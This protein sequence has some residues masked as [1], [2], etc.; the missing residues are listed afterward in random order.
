MLFNPF[1]TG[2]PDLTFFP[3]LLVLGI[4]SG[5]IGH[6]DNESEIGFL[7]LSSVRQIFGFSIVRVMSRVMV[8]VSF[9]LAY[10]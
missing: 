3:I 9:G 5:M 2:K 4:Y 8:R 6:A 10:L 7:I 1:G